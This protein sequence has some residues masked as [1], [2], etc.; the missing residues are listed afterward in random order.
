MIVGVS[1]GPGSV[2]FGYIGLGTRNL[3]IVDECRE[4]ITPYLYLLTK[5]HVYELIYLK[6]TKFSN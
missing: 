3:E 1:V 4:S 2:G 5:W 6:A